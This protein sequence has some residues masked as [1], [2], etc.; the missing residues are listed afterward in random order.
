MRVIWAIWV[1]IWA[2]ASLPAPTLIYRKIKSKK[3]PKEDSAETQGF[4]Y[5]EEERYRQKG[6]IVPIKIAI[7]ALFGFM[8]ITRNTPDASMAWFVAFWALLWLAIEVSATDGSMKVKATAVSLL[9]LLILSFATV[10]FFMRVNNARYFDSFITK[11]EGFPIETEVPNN[12]LRLTTKELATS[13]VQQHLAE[14]GSNARIA[15]IQV[16]M[17]EGRLVWVALIT[18]V[19]S[20]GQRYTIEG[21]VVVDANE[22]DRPPIINKEEKF[23]VSD[24]LDFNPVFGA[25]GN[26]HARGYYWINTALAY[27]D[28]YPVRSPEGTWRMA[29]TTYQPD[30]LGVRGYS[31]VYVLDKSGN[32]VDWYGKGAPDWLIQPFDEQVFLE[33]GVSDWGNF[34]RGD[35]FD[36]WAGGFL[37]IPQSAD[38]VSI[39][40]DTRYIY[41]PDVKQVVALVLV[42]PVREGGELTLAGAFKATSGGIAYYDLRS[43]N[44]ISGIAASSVIKSKITARAGTEYFTAMELLYP[45]KIGGETRQVWFVPVYFQS[46]TTGIIGLAGL[47]LVD[48]QDP[49]KMKIEYTGEGVTGAALV[50]KT[51]DGFRALFGEKPGTPSEDTTSLEGTLVAKQE[52]Y[53]VGGNTRI[54]LTIESNSGRRDVLVEAE[55][56]TDSEMLKVQKAQVGDYLKVEVDKNGVVTKVF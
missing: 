40:E 46:T 48:A 51:K 42:N 37:S 49:S 38:R 14:F 2:L 12:L 17:Y 21:F 23:A 5:D 11:A 47:G 33:G 52:P 1:L 4:Y 28:A 45:M 53:T 26:A 20:W 56:L 34:K 7:T 39:S 30:L 3:K 6:L 25:W 27:G 31:G 9:V 24:G 41:D 43:W 50:K 8:A 36:V 54:W 22:P 16:T 15:G 32:V 13:I 19:G 44:L 35:G 55:L 10:G 18:T 29:M